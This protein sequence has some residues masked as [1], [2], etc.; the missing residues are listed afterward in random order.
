MMD[1]NISN[2][3]ADDLR[4]AMGIKEEEDTD[5]SS[6]DTAPSSMVVSHINFTAIT[7]DEYPSRQSNNTIR[8]SSICHHNCRRRRKVRFVDEVVDTS[9]NSLVT[10]IAFRPTT[11]AEDKH[12]LYYTQKDFTY[13]AIEEHYYQMELVMNKESKEIVMF[14]WEDCIIF[15]SIHD[16]T[17]MHVNVKDTI[18]EENTQNGE[19][20]PMQMHKSRSLR[21]FHT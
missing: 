10:N 16:H 12:I 7:M 5:G 21:D 17:D 4:F 1:S 9:P 2:S 19:E 18:Q 20:C 15:E 8:S 13:F 11:R 3:N 14:G 6:D